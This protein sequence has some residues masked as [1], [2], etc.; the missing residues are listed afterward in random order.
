MRKVGRGKFG[1]VSVARERS[2]DLIVALKKMHKAELEDNNF[3]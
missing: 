2:S 1:E 3:C